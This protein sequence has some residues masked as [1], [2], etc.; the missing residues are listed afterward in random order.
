[1]AAF[2]RKMGY[3]P[4]SPRA[5][6]PGFDLAWEGGGGVFVAEVKSLSTK[7]EEKQLRLG[8]G[9]VLRYRDILS[10]P[11]TNVTAALVVERQPGDP[12][13]V[14]LCRSLGVLL[15][16]PDN[17]DELATHSPRLSGA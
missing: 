1:L 17:F 11:G 7:N 5:G 2:V 13:W 8:L 14:L 3:H 12:T 9:Q 4:R 6:E 10:G 16:W 15:V